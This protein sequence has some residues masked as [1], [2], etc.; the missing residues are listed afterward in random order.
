MGYFWGKGVKTRSRFPHQSTKKP[1]SLETITGVDGGQIDGYRSRR[2]SFRDFNG[3]C[4]SG[5]TGC[6]V[7]V[8]TSPGREAFTLMRNSFIS[9]SWQ[10]ALG[11]STGF[12][13]PV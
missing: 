5:I 6:R 3:L 4:D 1:I 13:G 2:K 9:A 8:Y 11:A 7:T 10:L 12:Q